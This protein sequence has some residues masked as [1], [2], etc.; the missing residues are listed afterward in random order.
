MTDQ[1]VYGYKDFF[2]RFALVFTWVVLLAAINVL[3]WVWIRF[4]SWIGWL[5]LGIV[6]L[7]W[8][9]RQM[10]RISAK[11]HYKFWTQSITI[12]LPTGK[13][14]VLPRT[15]IKKIERLDRISPLQGWGVKYLFWK[16]ELHFTTSTRHLLRI[17]MDDGRVIL[18][19][20]KEYPDIV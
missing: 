17:S 13:E 10:W 12:V 20:P 15:K 1:I 14:F 3:P 16:Q 19:S 7:G 6:I 2:A 9:F 4:T 11:L 18:I 5:L 8:V